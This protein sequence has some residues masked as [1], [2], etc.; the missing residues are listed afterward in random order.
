[1]NRRDV[2]LVLAVAAA[3]TVLVLGLALLDARR[4]GHELAELEELLCDARVSPAILEGVAPLLEAPGE[5]DDR[6]ACRLTVQVLSL[7][8]DASRAELFFEQGGLLWAAGR[9][10]KPAPDGGR[11]WPQAIGRWEHVAWSAGC[12]TARAGEQLLAARTLEVA[13]GRFAVVVARRWRR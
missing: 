4:A 9:G 5:I 11:R 6:E 10:L 3:V 8:D 13:P 12:R 2:M 7:V 1:M